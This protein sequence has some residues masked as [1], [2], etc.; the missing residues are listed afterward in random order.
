MNQEQPEATII[1]EQPQPTSYS[2]PY[3]PQNT[4]SFS[5]GVAPDAIEQPTSQPRV[6]EAPATS[7]YETP[8]TQ[9]VAFSA[10]VPTP[11]NTG[12]QPVIGSGPVQ[13]PTPTLGS[14][15]GGGKKK[16]IIAGIIALV[17]VGLMGGSAFAY[18]IY[19]KPENALLDAAGKALSAKRVHAKTTV[20]S[21]FAYT[22]GETKIT[23]DKLTFEV[24]VER[25]PTIDENAELGLT[26]NGKA[27]SL[28]VAVLATDKGE[29][30]FRVSN[31]KDTI[32][33]TIGSELNMTVK[34][35]QY[36]TNIDGKWAKYTLDEL[37]K[38]NPNSGK[39]AQCTIDTYKKYKDD[40]KAIQESVDVY[41]KNQ[42]VIVKGDPL[43][44]DG[45]IGYVVDIDK[46]KV[47]AFD[48]AW[49]RTAMAK[50]LDACDGSSTDASPE[51]TDTESEPTKPSDRD[52]KTVTTVW[53]SQW[54]HTL[55]SIETVT[56]NISGFDGK[57]FTVTTRTD[58]D[59]TKGVTTSVPTDAMKMNDWTE[60]VTKFSEELSGSAMSGITERAGESAAQANAMMV[61]KRAEV[62]NSVNGAYPTAIADF[63]K[64]QES[65]LEDV[66]LL[67]GVLPQDQEHIAYKKCSTDAGAQV[68][69]KKS[70]GTFVAY[71]VGR[72]GGSGQ[73]ITAL[74]K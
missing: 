49:S 61:V 73:T 40:K 15:N 29:I 66:S 47:K 52:P 7:N 30:Y 20:T 6:M 10:P 62:Y 45:N 50:E 19:Q 8:S 9:P 60:N 53:I 24:G 64:Y 4:Q 44:K 67:V 72:E 2:E 14:E 11:N 34:A 21:D 35:E 51:E 28:K 25:T 33:K 58:F 22:A 48:K 16:F 63:A 13:P 71:N 42:F 74:C 65:K 68:V 39:T 69:Y 32:K 55:D 36:L 41:K 5:E 57:K 27:V 1:P 12:F 56:S 37:K 70:D 38:D 26:Y 17:I 23:F 18:T 54:T 43:T 46:T 3:T 31:L 59:F